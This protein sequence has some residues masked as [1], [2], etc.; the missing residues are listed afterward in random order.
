MNCENHPERFG[1]FRVNGEDFCSE[2][3]NTRS[4][5]VPARP[6]RRDLKIMKT[7]F[8]KTDGDAKVTIK[9][10]ATTKHGFALVIISNGD[11]VVLEPVEINDLKRRLEEHL[12]NYEN[13]QGPH[14]ILN[15][16]FYRATELPIHGCDVRAK[17]PPEC[18]GYSLETLPVRKDGSL[19]QSKVKRVTDTDKIKSGTFGQRHRS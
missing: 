14:F 7:I 3:F 19:I 13:S 4:P 1:A 12:D 9:S 11:D 16:T 15:G 6:A 10:P 8:E 2:C 17:L 5:I 18:A